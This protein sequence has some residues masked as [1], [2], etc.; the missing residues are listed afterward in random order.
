[1]KKIVVAAI[2]MVGIVTAQ[3]VAPSIEV[4]RWNCE[5]PNTVGYA[6]SYGTIQ[7][8][9]KE[10]FDSLQVNFEFFQDKERKVLIAQS[11]GYVK[12]DKLAPDAQTTFET[13]TKVS[14]F[15]ACWISFEGKNG[16]LPTKYPDYSNNPPPRLP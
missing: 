1:M 10:T 9:S 7:N 15:A 3:T 2:L 12:A 16:I 6:H 5:P 11:S 8:T 4:L 14:K 13:L